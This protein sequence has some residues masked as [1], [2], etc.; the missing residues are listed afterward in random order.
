MDFVVAIDGPAA[1]GKGALS[2]KL[3][4]WFGLPVLDTGRLYRAVGARVQAAGGDP[5]DPKTAEAAALCLRLDD[6]AGL[7]LAS[8]SAGDLA[9]RVAVHPDVRAVVYRLQRD[10]GLRHGG[11]ILDGR[12]IGTVIFPEAP[13][14]IFIT[15]SP[16][17]RANRRWRQLV[18]ADP[19]VKY[20]DVLDDI[21]ARDARDASRAA[22]PMR[23]APDAALLATTALDIERSFDAARRIV[24]AARDQWIA[25]AP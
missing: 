1:S 16:E 14:K 24:A 4:Q 23:A 7:D 15:A 2:V 5:D 17:V 21:R 13:A 22:A 25:K 11:A 19:A 8:G 18:A 20:A 9:S 10:F 12:D 6:L 3:G